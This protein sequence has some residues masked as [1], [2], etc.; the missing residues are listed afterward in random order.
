[1]LETLNNM[2][3]MTANGNDIL[4]GFLLYAYVDVL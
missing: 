4:K 2:N 1:M 3:E